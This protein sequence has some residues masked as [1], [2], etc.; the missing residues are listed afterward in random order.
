MDSRLYVRSTYQRRSTC[1]SMLSQALWVSSIL[2]DG[3]V[4]CSTRPRCE[5]GTSS[6]LI[7]G[8]KI[9]LRVCLRTC[10]EKSRRTMGKLFLRSRKP[11]HCN[12]IQKK[13]QVSP[14]PFQV[15]NTNSLLNSSY[16]SASMLSEIVHELDDRCQ[17]KQ[18]HLLVVSCQWADQWFECLTSWEGL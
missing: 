18:L 8:T 12:T 11:F 17:S 16:R 15:A 1:D 2:D 5:T 4:R 9:T 10:T 13:K 14:G 3:S 7:V 6:L